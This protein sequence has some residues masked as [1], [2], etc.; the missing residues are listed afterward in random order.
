MRRDGGAATGPRRPVPLKLSAGDGGPVMH[1]CV[2][3]SALKSSTAAVS[4]VHTLRGQPSDAH[5]LLAAVQAQIR[6]HL[7]LAQCRGQGLASK[8]GRYVETW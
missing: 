1:S 6:H 7:K 4:L 5:A 8:R 2:G 3:D